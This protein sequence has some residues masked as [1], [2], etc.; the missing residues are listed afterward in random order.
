MAMTLWRSHE[1]G[2]LVGSVSL[3]WRAEIDFDVFSALEDE[4]VLAF[5][6]FR[7]CENVSVSGATL[8]E[9]L[10]VEAPAEARVQLALVYGYGPCEN[11]ARVA[12]AQH[13]GTEGASMVLSAWD[14]VPGALGVEGI[15]ES[16]LCLRLSLVLGEKPQ[17]V[18]DLSEWVWPWDGLAQEE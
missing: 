16:P 5:G 18:L 1:R 11:E 2:R 15:L 7:E 9:L 12:F 17:L 10:G 13:S 4:A 8:S 6:R 3:V 14:A